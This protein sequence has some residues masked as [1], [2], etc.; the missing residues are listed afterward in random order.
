M[1]EQDSHSV[2]ANIRAELMKAINSV[3]ERTL[4]SADAATSTK[5]AGIFNGKTL[6]S[7]ATYKDLLVNEAD[8]KESN[9][10][11]DLKYVLSPKAEADMKFMP[12]SSKATQLVME[13]GKVDGTTA[14]TTSF[15]KNH[16]VVYGDFG[17]IAVGFWGGVELIADQY[18]QLAI[19]GKI[20]LIANC[21]VDFTVVRDEALTFA[22]TDA[23]EI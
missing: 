10:F 16:K 21:Y 14:F 3:L 5:P 13:D 19:D 15:L 7:V 12:K 9:V 6:K 18:G 2:E 1:L 20:R 17:A 4:W 22:T 23:S 8:M 11:G